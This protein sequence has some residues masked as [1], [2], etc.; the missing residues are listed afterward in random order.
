MDFEAGLLRC[1]IRAC[2]G[3]RF[4]NSSARPRALGPRPSRAPCE[5]T[6]AHI[7]SQAMPSS[8]WCM[9]DGKVRGCVGGRPARLCN[10]HSHRRYGVFYSSS[11]WIEDLTQT[12]HAKDSVG[13]CSGVPTCSVL[14]LLA[15]APVL[16]CS[17]STR[18][19][20]RG[21]GVGNPRKET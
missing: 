12:F 8:N 14:K 17:H 2:A 15:W 13:W 21:F 20:Q 16:Q 10:R 9:T 11:D 19:C 1:H 7:L 6:I 4:W 3:G 5:S 18:W